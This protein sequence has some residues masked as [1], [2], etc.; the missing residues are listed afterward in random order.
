MPILVHL[1]QILLYPIVH[2]AAGPITLAS[3]LLGLFI[4]V[5]A[6]LVATGA[7]R[8]L[9][10]VLVHRGVHDSARFAIL[11]IVRYVIVFLGVMIAVTSIGLRLDALLAA[12]AALLVGIGFGLQSI[13]Q[14]FIS[15]LILL[16]ERP[17]GKGDFVQIGATAGAVIDIG[18]RATK[19]VTRDEV[20]II[21]PNSE[22]INGQVLNHSIPTTR[23]RIS[24]EVGVAYGSDT[25]KVQEVLL[26]VARRDPGLLAEPVAEV[27]FES[28]GDSSLD[29]ALLGWIAD[30]GDDRRIA[31][32]LR[33]AIDA[34]F[35]AH[36]IE[37][38][39][40]QRDLHVRS[41]LEKLTA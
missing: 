3:L 26:E 10:R 23:K 40:P 25:A 4:I 7:D 31:S 21:V 14:N 35:R 20:T 17:V 11:K 2:L 41:G 37:I 16:I 22:L 18:M 8:G 27:R 12:S 5:T 1:K 32:R 33:F 28:F 39:F 19:V 36:R 15:G 24:V 38:P 34:A 6:R 29:F 13:A 30:P 9:T